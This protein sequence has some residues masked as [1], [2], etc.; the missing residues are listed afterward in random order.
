MAE[1]VIG[2]GFIFR[3]TRLIAIW[4]A[5]PFHLAIEIGAEVQ[6]FSWAA[7]AALVIW[8]TPRVRERRIVVP[9]GHWLARVVRPLDWFG[10]FSIDETTDRGIEKPV[11]VD[12]TVEGPD[13]EAT[14]RHG[15][16]AFATTFSRMPVTFW[17]AAP[18]L[19]VARLRR[20]WA[21]RAQGS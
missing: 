18:V 7:L 1:Y 14:E 19:A 6:V 8:V 13:G 11:V 4:V 2:L 5:I 12:S 15:A 21:G 16:D 20:R 3:R 9:P 10:R 17:F